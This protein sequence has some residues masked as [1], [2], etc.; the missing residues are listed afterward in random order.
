[1]RCSARNHSPKA[2][3]SIAAILLSASIAFGQSELQKRTLVING[4]SGEVLIYH[5]NNQSFI[6]LET[7][8]R[9]ARGSVKFQGD[10][11][12]LTI[13]GATSHEAATATN[14]GMT[15]SFM[16]A[17]VQALAAVKEWHTTLAYAIERGLPGDGSRIVVYR[18]RAAEKLHLATVGISTDQ[19]KQALQLLTNHF[20]QV[21]NWKNK[22]VDARKSMSAA[23]YSITPDALKKDAD[24][25]RIASCSQFLSAMLP[26]G[27]FNDDSS[28]H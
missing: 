16:A 15:P 6:D 23:N 4:S 12:T 3:R 26:S 21:D 10:Q 1:M 24:Y 13:P 14:E 18:D 28:C 17:A 2:F 27:Q 5:I 22:L 25:Q 11:I 9:I 8:A 7:L 20:S 19:D